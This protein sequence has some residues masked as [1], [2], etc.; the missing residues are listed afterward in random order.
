MTNEK[1]EKCDYLHT[2]VLPALSWLDLPYW[3]D[4][5]RLMTNERMI[6]N[7]MHSLVELA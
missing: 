6:E 7:F 2:L 4:L 1:V 5:E 3:P